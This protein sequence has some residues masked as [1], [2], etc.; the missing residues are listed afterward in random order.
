MSPLWRKLARDLRQ[1]VASSLTLALIVGIGVACHVSMASA[2]RDLDGARARYYGDARLADFWVDLERAPASVLREVERLPNVRRARGRVR[3][4]ALVE[5]PGVGEPITGTAISLP[6]ARR[7]VLNDVQLR[8]GTWFTRRDAPQAILNHRFARANGLR[9]GDRLRVTFLDAQHEL[10]IVGTAMSPEFVYL[11]P[12]AGGLAPDPARFGVIYCPLEFLRRASDQEGAFN[13]LVGQVSDAGP[14]ALEATLSQIETRLDAYGVVG[15]T[16]VHLQASPRFLADE[17]AGLEVSATILPGI[18]LLVATLLLNVLL[19]RIVAQQ[20][21]IVGTLRALGHSRWSV[22]RH[23]LAHGLVIGAAG[24]ALGLA[25]GALLQEGLLSVY[26]QFYAMP[27]IVAGRYPDVALR[28]FGVSVLFAL[29]GAARGARAAAKL[30]PAEAMRPPPPERGGQILLERWPWLWARL[31]FR[32]RLVL[33]T[34]F[35]NPFRTAVGVFAAAVSTAL[36]MT[37]LVNV[38]ALDYL[39]RFT[40]EQVR[41]EDLSASLR[42]PRGRPLERELQRMPGIAQSETELQVACELRRGPHR[43]RTAVTGLGPAHRLHTPRD[44]REEPVAIPA[45]GLVLSRKLAEILAVRP[46]EQLWLRPLIGERREV[47]AP[48]VGLVDSYM[49]LGAY[50]DQVYLSR[51]LGEEW[52]ANALL[53]REQ[54]GAPRAPLLAALTAR[55]RVVG[56]SERGRALTQVRETFG[57]SMGAMISVMVLFAG[58]IAFGS[59]LNAAYVSLSE[60]R[61][62]VGTLRCLGYTPGQVAGVFAA[63]SLLVGAAGIVLG[64]LLGGGLAV[65]LSRAYSTELYRFPVVVRAERI[66]QSAL[67][68]LVFMGGAQALLYR[69]V[70]RLDWLELLQVKE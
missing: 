3:Q 22:T 17:L 6:F 57:Q 29:L 36:I 35:R 28:G 30:V 40:F 7:P 52:C 15:T 26:R 47:A 10:L 41:H 38:D 18:F 2:Y 53:A 55:P 44:A 62:E 21:G 8:S 43:R 66:A 31:S 65:L 42:K 16:P 59:L 12:P 1:R 46:G 33:R 50:A 49:G 4:A 51:L 5:L 64:V 60:R 34:V 63:E 23:F 48:V 56:V 45:H 37:A 11:L 68:M 69:L 58:A 54:P 39:M 20:R 61:R 27:G 25:L 13:E 70:S 32:S 24:G 14:A 67:L 19:A 9:A